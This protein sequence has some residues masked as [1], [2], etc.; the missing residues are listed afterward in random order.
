MAS[1]LGRLAITLPAPFFDAR[2][3]VELARRAEQE[4]GYPAIWMA[5]TSGPDSFSLAGALAMATE[6]VTIGTGIVPVYNRT[7]A[8]LA[9]TAGTLAQLSNDRFVLGLGSS[10]HAIIGD[11]NG[12]PFEKPLAHVRECVAL[13]RQALAGTK[14]DY[15]GDVMRSHGLRIGSV[16][17][18]PVPI[19]VAALRE[20]MLELAGEIGD[21]LVI[22][23]FPKSALPQILA[24]Y[25][26]GAEHAGRDASGDEVVCRFQVCVT[27][28]V[29]GARGLVRA[30]FGGYLATPVYNRFLD[31]C[32]FPDEARG[33]AQG[34]ASKDRAATAAAMHDE[35]IDRI[36]ILGTAESCREQ[37]AAFVEAGV[38]TPVISP[39]TTDPAGVI[40]TFEAFAPALHP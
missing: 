7:P 1:P 33:I 35:L 16:P 23:W 32:G 36:T 26:K 22:N 24:A 40:R 11:W 27:D 19:Y 6:Q 29:P 8:V 9:M 5:E 28:D 18:Q 38:T 37:V 10:S 31:W 2:G 4:W 15:D 34:F 13:V 39:L 20:R 21:G 30:A 17:S 12:I 25:R 3:C 14:T